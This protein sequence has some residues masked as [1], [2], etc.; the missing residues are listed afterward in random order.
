LA[1]SQEWLSHCFRL[2][3]GFLLAFDDAFF[4]NAKGEVGLLFVD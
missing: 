3:L 4:E 1:D 2:R